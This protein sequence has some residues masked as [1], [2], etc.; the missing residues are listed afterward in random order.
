M[1]Q[2]Y[3]GNMNNGWKHEPSS[4]K[5]KMNTAS[6]TKKSKIK[7]WKYLESTK[8]D[9]TVFLRAVRELLVDGNAVRNQLHPDNRKVQGREKLQRCIN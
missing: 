1:W 8:N 5:L 7:Y 4:K 6:A 3:L 9:C 2:E